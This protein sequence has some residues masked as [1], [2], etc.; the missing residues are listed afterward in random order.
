MFIIYSL[1]KNY[2][3]HII[4]KKNIKNKKLYKYQN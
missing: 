1:F 2:L 4:D 3:N